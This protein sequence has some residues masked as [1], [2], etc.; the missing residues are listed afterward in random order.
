MGMEVFKDIYENRHKYQKEWKEK[1]GSKM[2]GY[3]CTYAPEE[4]MYA[5]DIIPVRILGSHEPQNVTEPHIFG[6]YCPFCRDVLAQGLKGRYD[7]LDGIMI[8]QS[9]LHI[10]QAYTS[11]DLHIPVDFSYYLNMPHRV[12]NQHAKP[13]LRQELIE[14]KNAIEAW[15]GKIILPADIDKGIEILN[16]TRRLLREIWD[17]RKAENPPIT[18]QE[19]IYM[20]LACQF[21]DKREVNKLLEEALNELKTRKLDRETG[22]RLMIIGS[23]DDDIAFIN[24]VET[25]CG[26]TFVIEDHCTGSRYFWNQVEPQEDR[27]AAL[28]ARYCDR[29]PCPTKD[30]VQP[31]DRLVWALNMAKEWG[32]EG[33]IVVQQKFCDPHEL[34]IPAFRKAFEA[35]G[36][37]TLFLE[38]DVTV[39]LGPFR[40]RVDAFLEMLR[41]EDLF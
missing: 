34:D 19:A 31:R 13:F 1:S 38:F 39:P 29:P 40:I 18:G 12:T 25:V 20:V 8:A 24:M 21:G 9:C 7:Y 26:A 28:A 4:I 2:V 35:A 6:M 22:N 10:R 23:E 11:W 37:P 17:L 27:Y 41:Q 30:W 15:T 16:T 33:A 3:F 36:I 5:A 14:F 32:V